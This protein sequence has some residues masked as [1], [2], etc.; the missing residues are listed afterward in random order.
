MRLNYG[1]VFDP[2]GRIQ[3]TTSYWHHTFQVE[4]PVL[5]P[6]TRS[7]APCNLV[8][9]SATLCM[10]LED[11]AIQ[12]F[13]VRNSTNS[14]LA[15][16]RALMDEAVPVMP[17]YK[18]DSRNKRAIIP[19]IGQ[20]SHTLFGT[21]TE[22][23]VNVLANHIKIIEKRVKLITGSFQH[24]GK[25]LTSFMK[26]IN[27]RIDLSIRTMQENHV[28]ISKLGNELWQAEHGLLLSSKLSSHLTQQASTASYLLHSTDAFLQALLQLRHGQLS[29]LVIPKQA[30]HHA[31]QH[32]KRKLQRHFSDFTLTHSEVEHYYE[33]DHFLYS[34]KGDY[35]YI[36][37][38]LPISTIASPLQVYQLVV[39]PLPVN[40]ST[41]HATVLDNYPEYF[42]ISSDR[43]YYA[44]L[45]ESQWSK[46]QGHHTLRQCH[47]QLPL[48]SS[49]TVS[50]P[51]ALFFQ[52]KHKIRE[53]C[54]FNFL[55]NALKPMVFPLSD[56]SILVS[57]I[58]HLTLRCPN[59]IRDELG[60]QFCTINI[61]C[62]CSLAADKFLIPAVLH[63]CHNATDSITKLHPIN[64]AILQHFL[65]DE[66]LASV[67]GDSFTIKPLS[68]AIPAFH[69]FTHKFSQF[70]A[71]DQNVKLNLKRIISAA[72]QNQ[73]IFQTL[74]DP[75]L[76]GWLDNKADAFTMTTSVCAYIACILGI[77][78][79]ITSA[80]LFR[81]LKIALTALA[82]LQKGPLAQAA[83]LPYNFEFPTTPVPNLPNN[84]SPNHISLFPYMVTSLLFLCLIII[85]LLIRLLWKPKCTILCLEISDGD[86]CKLVHVQPLNH[87]PT[88]WHFEANGNILD[89]EVLGLLKP[90]IMVQWNGLILNNLLT[91]Q[92]MAPPNSF[93][94]NCLTARSLRKLLKRKF[95]AKLVI[96]HN[97]YASYVPVDD[98]P[99]PPKYDNTSNLYPI[100]PNVGGK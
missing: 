58:S 91:N 2:V 39:S 73:Q 28:A 1:T 22:H 33:S 36:T 97:G 43:Q 49:A 44:M 74:S 24:E 42:A 30:L 77:V 55:P 84:L 9:N 99:S 90:T 60:C 31:I 61:P 67:H 10:M 52:Q 29:P 68:A 48:I 59:G 86:L 7:R 21:A 26:A 92:S 13:T 57:N 25:E 6:P 83:V 70:V 95:Y 75:I 76:A 93:G 53:A 3:P 78:S 12:S 80:I 8:N 34:R 63:G 50:C 47:T 18:E 46:C 71:A 72:K 54:D 81:K 27:K 45:T 85:V 40:K 96:L 23:D 41:S 79:L 98:K 87:C 37:I 69:L 20:I 89:V 35:L 88:M 100:L 19:F 64:L 65:S 32:V 51:S 38:K 15:K 5:V 94:I 4:M 62:K 56:N 14:R 11:A 17:N 66:L 16:L 82:V